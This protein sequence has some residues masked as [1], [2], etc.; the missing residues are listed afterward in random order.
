MSLH[1]FWVHKAKR[2]TIKFSGLPGT[3]KASISRVRKAPTFFN[4]SCD[5]NRNYIDHSRYELHRRADEAAMCRNEHE[6]RREGN[7]VIDLIENMI[8][9]RLTPSQPCC[10]S[11]A[12]GVSQET[13]NKGI[14]S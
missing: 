14:A 4:V 7:E 1:R 2:L 3:I 5:Q 6:G 8:A 10:V 12:S 13:V 9:L 11:T